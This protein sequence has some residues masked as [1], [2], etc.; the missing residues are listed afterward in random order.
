MRIDR[1]VKLYLDAEDVALLDNCAF[2]IDQ[3]NTELTEDEWETIAD[4]YP[5]S[6]NEVADALRTLI[7][8]SKMKEGYFF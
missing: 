7:D 3:I 2:L 4:E 6:L 1:T 5:C 8:F